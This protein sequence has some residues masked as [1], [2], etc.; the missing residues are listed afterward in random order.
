[1]WHDIS[2][3]E[4][5]TCRGKRNCDT[6]YE[7][8]TESHEEIDEY[9]SIS[10][11][12]KHYIVKC[13]GCDSIYYI[14]QEYCS[15]WH[16]EPPTYTQLPR[17][18]KFNQKIFSARKFKENL[19]N[20][21]I[22]P[23]SVLIKELYFALNNEKPM[24]AA[25]AIRSLLETIMIDF[26]GDNGTFADNLGEMHKKG[27]ASSSQLEILKKVVNIGNAVIHRG[28]I[29]NMYDVA[30]AHGVIESF[31]TQLHYTTGKADSI[32]TKVPQ[33]Q[34]KSKTTTTPPAPSP[35]LHSQ[36]SPESAD[37]DA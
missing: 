30:Q 8:T 26:V 15:E 32:D 24:L 6:L 23:S 12:Q 34:R 36:P 1:M 35:P 4:C 18:E 10:T 31:V 28:Y 9:N 27:Y 3:V 20:F 25:M 13:K 17:Y 11:Y 14:K 19:F 33:R 37:G 21:N 16:D 2:K 5:S 22:D 29:P 7:H